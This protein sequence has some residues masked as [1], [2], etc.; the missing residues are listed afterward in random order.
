MGKDQ[1]LGMSSQ[2]MNSS[3]ALKLGRAMS[4][5]RSA[6]VYPRTAMI[7]SSRRV[8]PSAAPP[9]VPSTTRADQ[10]DRGEHE[11][12]RVSGGLVARR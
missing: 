8:W 11:R 12:E 5:P 1:R 10:G 6:L 2:A 9:S 4:G 3:G 7:S